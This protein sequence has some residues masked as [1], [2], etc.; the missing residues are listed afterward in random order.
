MIH[1][2]KIIASAH[3]AGV[4]LVAHQLLTGF[5]IRY[6]IIRRA[7]MYGHQCNHDN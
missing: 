7:A 6:G 1:V 5:S 2:D 4:A 3:G